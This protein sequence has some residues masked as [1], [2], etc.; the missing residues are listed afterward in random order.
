ME[1]MALLIIL[2]LVAETYSLQR[3]LRGIHWK[4]GKIR[5]ALQIPIEEWDY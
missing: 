4:L 5:H 3:L 1:W 2:I